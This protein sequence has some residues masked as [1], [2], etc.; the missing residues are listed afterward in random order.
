MLFKMRYIM[1]N[2]I[3]IFTMLLQ[4]HNS[5]IFFISLFE[6]QTRKRKYETEVRRWRNIVFIP[7]AREEE[8]Q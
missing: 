3:A 4:M 2:Y 5:F 7:L 8:L 6:K 1:L